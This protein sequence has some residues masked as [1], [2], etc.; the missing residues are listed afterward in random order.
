[1]LPAQYHVLAQ[2]LQG[3][4]ALPA[5]RCIAFKIR[6]PLAK[7]TTVWIGFYRLQCRHQGAVFIVGLI[8]V[9]F[10]ISSHPIQNPVL[11]RSHVLHSGY[12]SMSSRCCILPVWPNFENVDGLPDDRIADVELRSNCFRRASDVQKPAKGFQICSTFD[13][14]KC[15]KCEIRLRW[16]FSVLSF[17]KLK[18]IG[19]DHC[20]L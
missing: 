20:I 7:E 14:G 18:I 13:F 5:N 16:L 6:L 4:F 15:H 8:A 2:R 10:Q 11:L 1:M 9:P 17:N 12:R 19:S 3:Q